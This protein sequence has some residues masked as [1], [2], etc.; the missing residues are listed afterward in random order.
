MTGSDP[1]KGLSKRYYKFLTTNGPV[2][3]PKI[4]KNLAQG[5][6]R[7]GPRCE[8]VWGSGGIAPPFLTSLV[9]VSAVAVNLRPTV[10]QSAL[11]SGAHLGPVTNFS[12][13]L[14]FPLDSWGFVIL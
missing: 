5:E 14:K 11:V 1:Q 10:G 7:S 13:S 6:Y 12:F 4:M 9:G 8:D 3:I 2:N